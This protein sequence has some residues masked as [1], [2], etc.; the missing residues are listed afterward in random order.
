MH[1]LRLKLRARLRTAIQCQYAVKCWF[2]SVHQE[3]YIY[4]LYF[5]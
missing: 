1:L 5:I 4:V 2:Q 3:E